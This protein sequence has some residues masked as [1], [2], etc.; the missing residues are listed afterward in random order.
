MRWK[1]FCLPAHMVAS[2]VLL[3][4]SLAGVA[5]VA[6]GVHVAQL[7]ASANRKLTPCLQRESRKRERERERLDVA[8]LD[9]ATAAVA[10][11]LPSYSLA[12]HALL[13]VMSVCIRNNDL[14]SCKVIRGACECLPGDDVSGGEAER[15]TQAREMQAREDRR[16]RK[17][18]R[19]AA[20]YQGTDSRC[21]SS[22]PV[23]LHSLGS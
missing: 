10:A 11:L 13:P 1:A 9:C 14:Y 3:P 23:W 16:G 18:K 4:S 8:G 19:R 5:A 7:M 20:A 21:E 15:A 22:V 2:R 17:S 12:S 6:G